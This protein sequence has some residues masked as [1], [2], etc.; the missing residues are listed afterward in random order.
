[1]AGTLAVELPEALDI[2]QRHRQLAERFVLGVDRADSGQVEHRV[3]QHR[4]MAGRQHESV[5]IG[6]DRMA[7]VEAQETLP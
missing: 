1:V 5:A 7:G 2:L 4:R 6:P 3:E